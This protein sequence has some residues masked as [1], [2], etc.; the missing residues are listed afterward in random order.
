MKIT[1]VCNQYVLNASEGI[2]I[3]FDKA[4][5]PNETMLVLSRATNAIHESRN[6]QTATLM[7]EP[8]IEALREMHK[9]DIKVEIA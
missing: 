4:V 8:M 1:Q 7:G 3:V 9:L 5:M 2:I 6:I